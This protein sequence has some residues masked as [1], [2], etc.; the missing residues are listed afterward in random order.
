[1]TSWSTD[2][3][4]ADL[5]GAAQTAFDDLVYVFY[6]T[7]NA[8]ARLANDTLDVTDIQKVLNAL[9]NFIAS[10]PIE[11]WYAIGYIVVAKIVASALI[12][13]IGLFGSLKNWFNSSPSAP[14][15]PT[16]TTDGSSSTASTVS[17]TGSACACALVTIA[18]VATADDDTLAQV[19]GSAFPP[20]SS[21]KNRRGIDNV[22]PQDLEYR[23][24]G[25]NGRFHGKRSRLQKRVTFNNAQA[26]SFSCSG[27]NILSYTLPDYPS[28]P[29]TNTGE[30]ADIA[31]ISKWWDYQDYTP[32]NGICSKQI[33]QFSTPNARSY[34]SKY[35]SHPYRKRLIY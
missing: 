11:V 22:T 18:P 16:P 32:A 35:P 13:V 9:R 2:Q 5:A 7:Q 15:G 25:P 17:C 29:N 21:S 4:N 8:V 3:G 28:T 19:D 26:Q 27:T 24:H 1:M 31:A 10:V 34:A 14:L 23:E 6:Q 33:Y 30:A 20:P 12:Y